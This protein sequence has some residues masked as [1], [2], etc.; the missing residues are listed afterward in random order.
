MYKRRRI[1]SVPLKK[2]PL[3]KKRLFS[4]FPPGALGHSPIDVSDC[5]KNAPDK[6]NSSKTVPHI[7]TE[8]SFR[9][10]GECATL[11]SIDFRSFRAALSATTA[12]ENLLH[13]NV[14]AGIALAQQ[15]HV[16]HAGTAMNPIDPRAIYIDPPR[17][18][19]FALG[20]GTAILAFLLLA[21]FLPSQS[22]QKMTSVAATAP[23]PAKDDVSE[24]PAVPEVS[25]VLGAK[26]PSADLSCEDQA[27][28]YFDPGCLKAGPPKESASSASAATT[29]GVA[30]PSDRT[31][32]IG[33]PAA[34]SVLPDRHNAVTGEPALMPSMAMSTNASE[35]TTP[36][37]AD[38]TPRKKSKAARQTRVTP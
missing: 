12:R 5:V 23:L 17:A 36:K 26:P 11:W 1:A 15:N 3:S 27:W 28:P 38:A 18:I 9:V 16:A 2:K 29:D 32:S 13:R 6:C 7:F 24:R 4:Q 22:T 37:A 33:L 20:A 8:H 25:R 21:P 31:S 14:Q 10:R 19:G 35:R 30:S 34:T